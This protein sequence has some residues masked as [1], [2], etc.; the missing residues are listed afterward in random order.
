MKPRKRPE[1]RDVE[2]G[3][4]YGMALTEMVLYG[5]ALCFVDG[6]CGLAGLCWVTA[7]AS[8]RR[9]AAVGAT[10]AQP[11]SPFIHITIAV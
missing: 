2:R 11:G 1:K 9:F 3:D 5:F 8:A 6:D 4:F 7:A 10:I